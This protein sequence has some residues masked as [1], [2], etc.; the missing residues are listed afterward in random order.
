[1]KEEFQLSSAFLYNMNHDE[2]QKFHYYFD[3]NLIKK[4]I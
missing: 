4:F 3:K 2:I 1:L